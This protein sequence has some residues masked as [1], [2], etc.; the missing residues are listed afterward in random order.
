MSRDVD[1]VAITHVVTTL[2]ATRY[3][4][5]RRATAPAAAHARLCHAALIW[6]AMRYAMIC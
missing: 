4:S 6:R 3:C 5:R 2:F 1:G